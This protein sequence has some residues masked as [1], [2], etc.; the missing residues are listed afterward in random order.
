MRDLAGGA[1]FVVELRQTCRI[2]PEI[3]RQELQRDRLAQAQVVR[4]IDLA[5]AAASEQADDPVAIVEDGAR[6]KAAVV[7][8]SR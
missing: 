1:N 5:H 3:L 2:A 8:R 6:R 4:A 7:D